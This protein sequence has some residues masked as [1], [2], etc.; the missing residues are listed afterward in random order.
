LQQAAQSLIPKKDNELEFSTLNPE[1]FQFVA[2]SPESRYC[3]GVR[4]SKLNAIAVQGAIIRHI[5]AAAAEVQ[6]AMQAMRPAIQ[7]HLD[8]YRRRQ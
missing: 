5:D 6:S 2:C 8:D 1:A 7:A 3:P 4:Y